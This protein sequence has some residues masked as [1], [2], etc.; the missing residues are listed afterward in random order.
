MFDSHT[1]LACFHADIVDKQFPNWSY[2][3]DDEVDDAIRS[4]KNTSLENSYEEQRASLKRKYEERSKKFSSEENDY[5]L[6]KINYR[7]PIWN[8]RLF[9]DHLP[10]LLKTDLQGNKDLT[11]ISLNVLG[12]TSYS[13]M[14]DVTPGSITIRYKRIL[15][16]LNNAAI[17][18]SADIICLQEVC[19]QSFPFDDLNK[20]LGNDW[21]YVSDENGLITLYRHSR[22]EKVDF[23]YDPSCRILS[24]QLKDKHNN[25]NIV[26]INN[27]WGFHNY[28]PRGIEETIKKYLF[29]KKVEE[30]SI[31]VGDTNSR[32]ADFGAGL[33]KLITGLIPRCFNQNYKAKAH[34]QIGDFPDGG[35]IS[36]TG[37]CISRIKHKILNFKTGDIVPRKNSDPLMNY[38]FNDQR[39]VLCIDDIMANADAFDGKTREEFQNELTE[40]YN[41]NLYVYY[42][43]N[44]NNKIEAMICGPS[45][46]ILKRFSSEFENNKNI[47]TDFRSDET[48]GQTLRIIQFPIHK[49]NGIFDFIK[50]E[51]A[52]K[53]QRENMLTSLNQ[54]IN[55]LKQ[56][57]F[58]LD[59]TEKV[60]ALQTLYDELSAKPVTTK[61]ED[62]IACIE[63]WEESAVWSLV[64]NENKENQKLTNKRILQIDRSPFTLLT[65]WRTEEDI[66]PNAKSLKNLNDI[67]ESLRSTTNS[68]PLP[69]QR[70]LSRS[71]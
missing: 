69:S 26:H 1:E 42:T 10:L 8:H 4:E 48:T 2:A 12:N 23:L 41:E 5:I 65:F 61:S 29:N 37:T 9:S 28:F 15:E 7:Y 21:H 35:F 13:N 14:I 68:R 33:K 46:G 19:I 47:I 16:G 11:I 45:S 36:K 20:L 50:A 49:N 25:E 27:M 55:E 34:E 71:G 58:L 39:P 38:K 64:G 3:L 24:T 59:G 70:N 40:L 66:N 62:Y 44:C 56:S 63:Q 17:K 60:L 43:A 54:T 67:K 53:D 32:I 30:V 18:N 22:F 52:C 57:R 51:K 31:V 6:N